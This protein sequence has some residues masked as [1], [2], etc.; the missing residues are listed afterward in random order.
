MRGIRT[1]ALGAAAA[2]SLGATLLP[3]GAEPR[4]DA[5]SRYVVR[6]QG[7]APGLRMLRIKD[8]RGPNR[9]KVLKLYP[10]SALTLHMELAT[11]E[12]PGHETT[13]SMAARNG[14]VAAING[15]FTLLPGDKRAGRP[16]HTFAEDAELVTSPLVWGR[17]FAQTPDESAVY[18]GH[19]KTKASLTQHDTGE[20]WDVPL[21]NQLP[22]TPNTY[23]VY[24]PRGGS[25]H[26]PPRNACAAR[27]FPVTEP[28]FSSD[29]TATE[30]TYYVSAARCSSSR[31]GRQGGTVIAARIGSEAGMALIAGLTVG[32]NVSLGWTTGWPAVN[33]TIGGNPTLLENGV[34][35]A[36]ACSD[37]YFCYRNPRTGIGVNAN[38]KILLV[39]VDGRRKG[40]VGMTPVQFAKLFRW[41]GATSALN[42]DGGGS[43]TM[44]VRGQIVNHPSGGTER[45][46]GSSILVVPQPAEPTPEPTPTPSPSLPEIETYSTQ[47]ADPVPVGCEVLGDPGST[48]GLVDYLAKHR[49]GFRARGLFRHALDVFRGEKSECA[50]RSDGLERF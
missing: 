9:I 18:I 26:P 15:D 25:N 47:S 40:S 34:I 24:T 21:W 5:A 28:T 8:N 42:L 44:W 20:A 13:S 38:G 1:V 22:L 50:P 30:Q 27:L 39:T 35:T 43:T 19:P 6:R 36:E 3:I 46:V 14:A 12:I 4:A 45:P 41:L 49:D 16:V 17:N 37:S 2:L 31:M 7:V 23:G 29:L 10:P 32:E 11:E 33:E 48:G